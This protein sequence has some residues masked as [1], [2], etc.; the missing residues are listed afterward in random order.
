[1]FDR[2]ERIGV[3]DQLK[4]LPESPLADAS[5][6]EGEEYKRA[7]RAAEKANQQIVARQEE[8]L[9]RPIYMR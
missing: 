9:L 5:A 3:V 7:K 6:A 8:R 1:M 2:A 4:A